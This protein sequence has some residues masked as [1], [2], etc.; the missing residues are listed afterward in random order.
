MQLRTW[1][2]FVSCERNLLELLLCGLISKAL[3]PPV[4]QTWTSIVFTI[5]SSK[6]K[7]KTKAARS[8]RAIYTI[9]RR[10]LTSAFNHNL[11][12]AKSAAW[13]H[14]SLEQVE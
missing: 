13:K 1:E 11:I 10:T 7:Q 8:M 3:R 4:L 2:F 12:A 9:P 14:Q 6:Q 5:K